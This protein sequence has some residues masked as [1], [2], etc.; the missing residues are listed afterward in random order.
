MND[1]YKRHFNVTNS[2][3][4]HGARKIT[5]HFLLRM[6]KRVKDIK[7]TRPRHGI[8][9][10]KYDMF[11]VV[12]RYKMQKV[13]TMGYLT[14]KSIPNSSGSLNYMITSLTQYKELSYPA[15]TSAHGKPS[16]NPKST[17][18]MSQTSTSLQKHTDSD[19]METVS[20][21]IFSRS[22]VQQM[23]HITS[24]HSYLKRTSRKPWRIHSIRPAP[25]V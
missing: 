17:T 23:I 14:L 7:F 19:P 5:A 4:P 12:D 3:P 20:K 18:Q 8:P 11:L 25:D 1:N 9:L 2:N 10:R 13:A 15:K 22:S 24:R 6:K 16:Q 21:Q